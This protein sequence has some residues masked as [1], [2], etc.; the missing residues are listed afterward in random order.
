MHRIAFAPAATRLPGA[1][2]ALLVLLPLL[3][4]LPLRAWAGKAY[5]PSGANERSHSTY[6]VAAD[7][8]HTREEEHAY[9]VRTA[10]GVESYGTRQ[11]GYISSQE[12]VL[13]VEAW[14]ETPDGTRIDVPPEAIR[15][16]DEDNSDGSA[17]FSDTRFKVIIYPRIEVGS[18]V[19]YKA[20]TRV[21]ET[22]Y[23]GVFK[24]TFAFSPGI[25]L[26][27]WQATFVLPASSTL[28]VEARGVTG[29]LEKTVEGLSYYTFRYRRNTVM[30]PQADAAGRIHYADYLMVSTLPDMRSLGRLARAFFEPHVEITPEIRALAEQLTAGVR[31]DRDKVAALYTWVAQNVRYVAV[32]LG[33]GRLV[34]R[35]AS[36]VLKNRYGDCKD[37]VV[38]LESLLSAVGIASSP[39]LINSSDSYRLSTI[40]V[41]YPIDHV[42]TYVPALDLYLD[43]TDPFAPFGTLPFGDYGKPVL[44]LALDRIARTPEMKAEEH[45]SRTEVTLDIRPDGVIAGTS[46]T[47]MTGLFENASRS[48]HHFA[49][50]RPEAARVK[51]L[52]Y[53]FNETGTGGMDHGDPADIT[54]PWWVKAHFELEPIANMPGR[55]GLPVPVGLAP[56]EIAG[57]A[58][59][60][61]EAESNFPSTCASRLVEERYTLV[62]P[63]NVTIDEVPRGTW[64]RQGDVRYE[65]RFVR[66]GQRVTVQRRLKVQ[67]AS[68]LCGVKE[69][70]DWL[71]FY[72][73]LQRDLRS[74]IIYR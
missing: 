74:Q 46:S 66:V 39:A 64:F 73:V 31:T 58:S 44:L 36:T 68:N 13:S 23:P 48:N 51:D 28:H 37:H 16:R 35:P 1:L 11:I 29:G 56:G 55:G 19:A 32:S 5:T 38:L 10:R 54:R 30:P 7:G 22:A 52:L 2:L 59:D 26:A 14:T 43:S 65:S 61:P 71:A 33:Q 24:Q 12:S 69:H 18:L 45:A 53:R 34:P 8:T 27:D 49:Q 50:S 40:G 60:K 47:R 41:Q 67:R 9:R 20:V 17:E 57:L 63:A 25:A 70:R 21:H 62:F 42:I 72:K 15:D 4:F 3:V 6:R